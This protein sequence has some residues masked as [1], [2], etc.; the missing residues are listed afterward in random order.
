MLSPVRCLPK[1]WEAVLLN[2]C[3]GRMSSPVF[4]SLA[5]KFLYRGCVGIAMRSVS[6]AVVMAMLLVIVVGNS[7]EEQ[8]LQ[9]SAREK[10]DA[11]RLSF[12]QALSD[13]AVC[14]SYR[15]EPGMALFNVSGRFDVL[16]MRGS[17]VFLHPT[18]NTSVAYA[19]HLADD[20]MPFWKSP[21]N[22]SGYFRV[23]YLTAGKY[24]MY[25][26]V[27]RF[28]GEMG[29]ER[30]EGLY[31]EDYEVVTLWVGGDQR[32]NIVVFEIRRV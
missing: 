29:F 28:G 25:I 30:F 32:W 23:D 9:V 11:L 13:A 14:G 22:E 7:C 21:V 27:R 16:P 4:R 10:A 18:K 1:Y 26:P 31:S 20:C 2:K 24:V 5:E 6:G 19:I 15:Y 8:E 12:Q 3:F 17:E